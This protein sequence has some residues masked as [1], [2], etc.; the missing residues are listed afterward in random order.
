MHTYVH[1]RA[2]WRLVTD[3]GG[4]M[5]MQGRASPGRLRLR[6]LTSMHVLAGWL[7]LVLPPIQGLLDVF[8]AQA[9]QGERGGCRAGL[10]R[11]PLRI[12]DATRHQRSG[13]RDGANG[14]QLRIDDAPH[15]RRQLLGHRREARGARVLASEGPLDHDG[16]DEKGGRACDGQKRQ[17]QPE[18]GLVLVE[19][20]TFAVLCDAQEAGHGD[21]QPRN[22]VHRVGD[23][24]PR[25]L[26]LRHPRLDGQP[27]YSEAHRPKHQRQVVPVGDQRAGDV[28]KVTSVCNCWRA[29]Q[30][31][32]QG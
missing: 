23:G 29:D 20:P 2:S 4:L 27:L 8:E 10:P 21:Q 15:P 16:R 14:K 18:N 30:Q 32:Q 9:A 25:L 3:F 31:R 11:Q 17:F 22:V 24:H 12:P 1:G 28:A 7:G 5:R 6:G 19:V 13:Q 26:L